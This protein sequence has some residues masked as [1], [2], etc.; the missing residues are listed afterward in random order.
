MSFVATTTVTILRG[1][2]ADRFGDPVDD[3]SVLPLATRW[4]ASILEKPVTG[5]KPVD[6]D[7]TTPRTYTMR[8]RPRAGVTL[9]QND[10][11]RDERTGATYT[12]DTQVS[13]TNPV[14]HT[15]TRFDLRRVT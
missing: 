12:V 7:T 13:P 10:R 2:A 15:V 14:G 9:R 6:G 5:G 3:D 8:V 1:E 4:P 11:V